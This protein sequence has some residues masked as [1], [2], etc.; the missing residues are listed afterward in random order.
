[1]LSE[2]RKRESHKFRN[3]T[4]SRRENL[5]F[6][7]FLVAIDDPESCEDKVR[8]IIKDIGILN[9][10]RFRFMRCHYLNDKKQIT[11][12]LQL[13]SDRECV[14]KNRYTLKQI[15]YY[16]AK[17]FLQVIASQRN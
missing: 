10:N 13:F 8:E 4:Y 16:V 9:V 3:E 2:N 11:A 15:T 14:W 7:V 5:V 1:M 6:C 17:Y 12:R